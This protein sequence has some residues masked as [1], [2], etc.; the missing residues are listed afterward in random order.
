MKI[1]KDTGKAAVTEFRILENFAQSSLMEVILHT[2]R[3]HQ[4]RVHA[5]FAGHPIAGDDKYGDKAFNRIMQKY[6]LRRLFLHAS[7][8]SFLLPDSELIEVYAPM[9]NRLITVLDKM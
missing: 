8:V 6:G 9:D 5:Q 3:T 1:E 7:Q 4:I 2:G